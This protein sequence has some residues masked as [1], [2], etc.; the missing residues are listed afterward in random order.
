MRVHISPVFDTPDAADGG[1]RRVCEAQLRYLPEF[2]VEVVRDASQA[3]LCAVHGALIPPR[4]DVPMVAHCHGLMWS[5]YRWPSYGEAINRAVIDTMGR[6]AAVTAPSH[7]V[8]RAIS[9]GMLLRPEVIYHGVDAD[10]WT[11]EPHQGYVLWNKARADAVSDPTPLGT[12]ASLLPDVPFITTF[13]PTAPNIH[14]TGAMPLPQMRDYVQRAGV[15]LAT[16]RETFGIGTLEA[17]AAGVPIVGW[18]YGGQREIVTEDTGI[19]VEEGD[20]AALARAVR[21]ALAARDRLGAAAR[22]D[23]VERWDWRTRIRQYAEL[24]RRV[25]EAHTRPQPRVSVVITTYNLAEY[26]SHAISTVTAQHESNTEIIVVDDCSTD[27][28]ADVVKRHQQGLQELEDERLIYHRTPQNLGL[29]GARNYGAARATGRY[30]LF[31]DADDALAPGA[32][33]TLSAALD[34]DAGL[35]VAAGALQIMGQDGPNQWPDGSVDFRKQSAHLNQLHYAAMWRRDAFQRTGGYRTRDWR[36]EDASHWLRAMAGGLRIKQVTEEPTLLYRVRPDSKSQQEAKLHS[37]RDGDWTA[38]FPWRLGATS[39]R[40]GVSLVASGAPLDARQ[41]PFGAPAPAPRRSW[42]VWHHEH[43]L[44]SVVIPVGPGHAPFLVDALDSLTAQTFGNWE[45]IVVDDG[46]DTDLT[47]HPW[48]VRVL[49]MSSTPW[50]AGFA[51]NEG[52]RRARAPL[53]LF[54]DADDVLRPEALQTLVSAYAS[55]DASYIYPDTLVVRAEGRVVDAATCDWLSLPQYTDDAHA[56]LSVAPAAEYEQSLVLSSGYTAGRPGLHSVTTL[57]ETEAA[58]AVGGFDEAMAGFED[59]EFYLRLA[60]AGYC[61]ARVPQPLLI[62]RLATGQRR[63]RAAKQRTALMKAMAK[64]YEGTMPKKSCCGGITL[65]REKAASLLVEQDA[66]PAVIV[67]PEATSVRLRYVGPLQGEHTITGQ[68]SG[69]PY[70]VGNNSFNKF[71]N[72][73][74]RDVEH[75]MSLGTEHGE[76]LF[77]VVR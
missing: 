35:H 63:Q 38:W 30:L 47:G 55:G 77:E 40:Q 49:N 44:I 67:N 2:G 27:N 59:W 32:L 62:Y 71:A 75:L 76:R 17:L 10:Q 43:P 33:A 51:R 12:L 60:S 50:G 21:T 36:A 14:V 29:S 58:R 5:D 57:V 54:L 20:Y 48:A 25:H 53:L 37:D 34:R 7:W 56:P 70:R 19:L 72:V 41:V 31:L 68:P 15:Y 74:P 46:A 61:G 3:D 11:P 13:G 52:L 6:A 22:R 18:N 1:I 16:A 39:G 24:Y 28:T 8:A 9:R 45:A 42:P 4:G 73:D 66:Q 65:L 64:K 69:R 26:V 23:A